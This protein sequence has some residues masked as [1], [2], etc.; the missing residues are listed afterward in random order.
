MTDTMEEKWG[1]LLNLENESFMRIIVGDKPL[2]YFET[3]V[4]EW[5]KQGGDTITREVEKEIAKQK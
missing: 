3:F 1:N 2:D 5:R 4:S